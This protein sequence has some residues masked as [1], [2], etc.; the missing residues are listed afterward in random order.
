[1]TK[2]KEKPQEL[3]EEQLIAQATIERIESMA[4]DWRD[5]IVVQAIAEGIQAKWYT[6][7]EDIG[8]GRTRNNKYNMGYMQACRDIQAHL[9][10]IGQTTAPTIIEETTLD[11]TEPK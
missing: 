7:L 2:K 4:D 10:N 3:T 6:L 1:M 5:N 8:N 11:V 9:T